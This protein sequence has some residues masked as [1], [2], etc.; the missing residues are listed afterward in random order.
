MTFIHQ[1]ARIPLTAAQILSLNSS[2][3]E[4]IA[5]TPGSI[6]V[7]YNLYLRLFHGTTPFN[8]QSTDALV[9]YLGN[10]ENTTLPNSST[11]AKGFV[12]QTQDMSS[13]QSAWMGQGNAADLT[14]DIKGSGL[15][16][17]Q[18]NANDFPS[19]SNWTQ[20]N[21]TMLALIEYAVVIP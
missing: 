14:A 5:G 6:I 13:W 16:L 11:I 10:L 19:G 15:W 7:T 4:L 21:G 3:V 1:N 9:Y 8:P 20:G 17:T 18:C 12:D 2:P